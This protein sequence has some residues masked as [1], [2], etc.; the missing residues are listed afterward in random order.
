MSVTP[1]D[2]QLPVRHRLT[3]LPCASL[4]LQ[5]RHERRSRPAT[6]SVAQRNVSGVREHSPE[7]RAV[8][9]AERVEKNH[10][11]QEEVARH[12][13]ELVQQRR[14]R[15][16][17]QVERVKEQQQRFTEDTERANMV[18]RLRPYLKVWMGLS[19]ALGRLEAWGERLLAERRA[20]ELARRREW[21]AR[22]L[23][24]RFLPVVLARR[25]LR[26]LRA[27]KLLGRNVWRAL[28]FKRVV[29][30]RR[31]VALIRFYLSGL[32]HTRK[33]VTAV[34]AFARGVR[35]VQRLV[36]MHV[37]RR[38]ANRALNVEVRSTAIYFSPVF[39]RPD[40]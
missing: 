32:S 1:S 21:A 40:L 34:E 35:D 18:R 16:E 38:W 36:R 19:C 15:G 11:H 26:A 39:A 27:L 2:H 6:A 37:R 33:F 29:K 5:L 22:T 8:H 24:T 7:R 23:Q 3:Y 30:K 17:A 20:T 13:A 4:C 31:A 12:H 28:L 14:E 10:Q 9:Q 25:R